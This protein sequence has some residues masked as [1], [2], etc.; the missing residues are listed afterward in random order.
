MKA[1]SEQGHALEQMLQQPSVES[2][3]VLH[4]AGATK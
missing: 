2:K 1:A 4:M 3:L